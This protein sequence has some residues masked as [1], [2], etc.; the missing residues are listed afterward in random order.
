MT[1]RILAELRQLAATVEQ[2]V[3]STA[4]WKTKYDLV[5]SDNVCVRIR[6]LL[7]ELGCSLNY[8]DPDT[9][10]E[11]DLRAYADALKEKMVQINAAFAGVSNGRT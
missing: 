6:Q 9:T 5:F 11:E 1:T 10:Y 8:Y 2:I 3:G 7:D 4:D